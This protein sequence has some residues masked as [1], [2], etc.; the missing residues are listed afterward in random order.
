[1]ILGLHSSKTYQYVK[2]KI[3]STKM[4]HLYSHFAEEDSTL[5]KEQV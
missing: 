4:I 2:K 3:V 1:M 5:K